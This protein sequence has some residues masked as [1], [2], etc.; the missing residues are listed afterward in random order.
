MVLRA[1]MMPAAYWAIS[2]K[3][4]GWPAS[5]TID[6]TRG[7]WSDSRWSSKTC[8][9]RARSPGREVRPDALVEAPTSLGDGPAHLVER[10]RGEFGDD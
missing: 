7:S 6:A 8:R 9:M 1:S 10:G 2:A 4:T 5:A 3:R